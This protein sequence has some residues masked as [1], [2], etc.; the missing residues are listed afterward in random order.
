M[1]WYLFGFSF[2]YIFGEGGREFQKSPYKFLEG[3]IS[4]MTFSLDFFEIVELGTECHKGY[5]SS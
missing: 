5:N 3:R 4:Y 1:D 2:S